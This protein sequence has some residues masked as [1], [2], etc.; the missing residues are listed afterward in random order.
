MSAALDLRSERFGRRI[1]G[2]PG[3]AAIVPL[4][5]DLLS[6]LRR[7]VIAYVSR[8]MPDP[9]MFGSSDEFVAAIERSN[10]RIETL[11]IGGIVI[12]KRNSSLEY[13]VVLRTFAE[14]V[15]RIAG[16]HIGHWHFPPNV[17]I[18]F[19]E[20]TPGQMER[21][22]PSERPHSDAWAGEHPDS[23]TVHIPLFGD[24]ALNRVAH[25]L[26]WE[27][28]EENW[29]EPCRSSDADEIRLWET[30]LEPFYDKV[31]SV[32][33]IGSA[34]LM[35]ASVLHASE[36]VPGC[37]LRVSIEA[38]FVWSDARVADGLM[39]AEEHISHR[40]ALHA[41]E[42]WFFY[43]PDDVRVR[44][45]TAASTRHAAKVNRIELERY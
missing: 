21:P 36:R 18:K 40:Q 10:G 43:F 2:F 11:S 31:E 13:N 28:F 22:R 35:D 39:R 26:P 41:G 23:V 24:C 16:P 38:P 17:R 45:E 8:S 19:G 7:A 3:L 9:L 1:L 15:D 42:E 44:R 25:W 29:L 12:P 33:P 34:L 20:V 6:V 37:G 30:R 5:T 32:T 14:I 27:T 4:R